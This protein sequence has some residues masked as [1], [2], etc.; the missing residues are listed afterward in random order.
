MAMRPSINDVRRK[1][2]SAKRQIADGT[3]DCYRRGWHDALA[4]VV[5]GDQEPAPESIAETALSIIT[6]T[7]LGHGLTDRSTPLMGVVKRLEVA[8]YHLAPQDVSKACLSLCR[9]GT[10]TR[11]P[12]GYRLVAEGVP[13]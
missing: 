2:E 3:A 6:N 11:T 5:N 7:V 4:F 1:L 13:S 8:G 12:Q 10:I 9:D